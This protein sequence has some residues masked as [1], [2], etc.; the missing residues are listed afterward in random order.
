V[1]KGGTK[2]SRFEK[3]QRKNRAKKLEHVRIVKIDDMVRSGG[4]QRA[5][6]HTNEEDSKKIYRAFS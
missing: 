5:R 4:G 3:K 1:R 2:I 6:F